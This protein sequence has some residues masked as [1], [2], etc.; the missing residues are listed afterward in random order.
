MLYIHILPIDT[1]KNFTW[2]IVYVVDSVR[3]IRNYELLTIDAEKGKYLIDEK[4]SIKLEGYLLGGKFFQ[5]FEVM[6]SLLMTSTE[7]INE[8]EMIWE[9]ISGSLE[10]VSNTGGQEFEGQE[11]PPV[12]GYGIKVMQRAS[13]KKVK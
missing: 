2:R 10:P 1:S 3:Q 12:R 4:N 13:L 7:K 9:I 11:I 6:G 8:E 5:R